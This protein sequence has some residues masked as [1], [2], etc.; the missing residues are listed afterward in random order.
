MV[1]VD[2]Q[3]GRVAVNSAVGRTWPT[4]L[5]RDPTITVT[6]YDEGNPYEYV[7]VRGRATARTEGADAHIDGLAKKYLGQDSYP[8]RQA[9]EQRIT[10]LVE[11]SR[12]RHQKPR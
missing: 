7:E 4:N 6:V 12:V 2:V 1:W 11:R 10:F 3:D 5:D 8:D 9:D